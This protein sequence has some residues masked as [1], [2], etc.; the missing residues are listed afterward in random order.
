LDPGLFEKFSSSR[1]SISF[2][3]LPFASR[4]NK[5]TTSF[6]RYS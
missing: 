5:A 6:T 2:S 4:H 1:F 3:L